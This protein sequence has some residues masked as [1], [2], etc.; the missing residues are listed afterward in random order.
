MRKRAATADLGLF[1]AVLLTAGLGVAR[2]GQPKSF[3][4]TIKRLTTV[5][6]TVPDNGDQNPYALVVA[7]VAARSIPKDDVLVTNF[8]NDGNLLGPG[9]TIVPLPR[10]PRS[11]GVHWAASV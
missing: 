8:N 7:P 5:T 2:A 6:L 3:L 10:W 4:D 11:W 9:T 1:T